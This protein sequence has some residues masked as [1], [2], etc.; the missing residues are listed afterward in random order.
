MLLA[1]DPGT[2]TGW[3]VFDSARRLKACGLGDPRDCHWTDLAKRVVIEQPKIYPNGG[4][5]NPN[6]VLKLAVKAGEWSGYF[7]RIAEVQ[8]VVP[9]D[10]KGKVPKAIQNARDWDRLAPEEKAIVDAAARGMAA[11]K[12]HNMLDAVGIGLWGVGR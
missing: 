10:W 12:R 7:G 11:S 4:T 6:D 2:D 9:Q 8:Y 3:A 5:K 1:I